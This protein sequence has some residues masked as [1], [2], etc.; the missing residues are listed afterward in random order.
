MKRFRQVDQYGDGKGSYKLYIHIQDLLFWHILS[1]MD[2]D[3]GN[4]VLYNPIPYIQYGQSQQRIFTSI[5]RTFNSNT[6][7]YT[8]ASYRW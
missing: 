2:A 1:P 8:C 4:L 3:E 7:G 5:K 6:K